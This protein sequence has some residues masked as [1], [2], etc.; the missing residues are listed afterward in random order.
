MNA[1]R[2]RAGRQLCPVR[3]F[4]SPFIFPYCSSTQSSTF[5]E[6]KALPRWRSSAWSGSAPTSRRP[7]ASTTPSTH[8]P[9]GV[10]GED[11]RQA[12]HRRPARAA[13]SA[14]PYP[15][16][17]HADRPGGR[18]A[19]HRRD[20]AWG[21]PSSPPPLG[22]TTT[23]DAPSAAPTSQ[24]PSVTLGPGS[25]SGGGRRSR[26]STAEA[27]LMCNTSASPDVRRTLEISGDP[28]AVCG[29]LSERSS[30]RMP[31]GM[32]RSGPVVRW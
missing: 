29:C 2:A 23:P 3:A 19:M 11:Q 24:L 20:H 17:R 30:V 32:F 8:L 21:W 15:R 13:G 28:Q 7:S 9:E 25:A 12:E 18:P 10:R 5:D 16:R 22:P 31:D 4:I 27:R 1:A 14:V 26:L 6:R